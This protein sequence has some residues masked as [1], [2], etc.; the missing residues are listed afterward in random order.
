MFASLNAKQIPEQ[1]KQLLAL[2]RQALEHNIQTA[3]PKSLLSLLND[4]ANHLE[5]FWSP[6]GHLNSVIGSKEWRDCY[7]ECLPLLTE[8][9][10]FIYQNQN[11]Y[12][13]LKDCSEILTIGENKMLKDFLLGCQLSGIH[14]D[15]EKRQQVRSLFERL[16][17]LSQQFQNNIVDSMKKF[18]FHTLD[19]AELEGLPEHVILN[20][21]KKAQDEQ[22]SGYVLGLD[23]PTYIAVITYAKNQKLRK[24]F[25]KAYGTRASD[26]SDY[27]GNQFDNTDVI[28]E[29]LEK[30]QQLAGLVG[31]KNYAAYSLSNKMAQEIARV[32][33]FLNR[34]KDEVKPITTCDVQEIKVFAKSKG[35]EKD[36]EPWDMAY[37]IQMRQQELFSIDQEALRD[38]FP[39]THV[40]KGLNE[41]FLQLYGLNLEKVSIKDTWHSD[42]E[43]YQLKQNNKTIGYVYCDWFSREGK[44]GGAWM[45]TLQT[46]CR[47][48]D[49][50]IQHAIAT[51]TCNFAKPAPQQEAGLTH[52]ELLTLLHEF[53]HCMHHI[54]SEVDEFSVSGVHGVEWDAVELPSQWMENWGWVEQWLKI[55]SRH[56][57]TQETLPHEVFL[58]LLKVKNDLIGLY[59]SRQIL[60]ASYDIFIHSQKAPQSKDEVHQQYLSLLTEIAVWPVDYNQRFPQNFS[61]IFAGGYAAG[62]Y[63]YLWADV[64]SSDAFEWFAEDLQKISE[65]GSHFRK[66]IMSKGGSVSALDAFIAFRGREPDQNALLRAYGLGQSS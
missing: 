17:E 63:S 23:Q 8:H 28:Q 61:H 33:N 26:Q 52:E 5:K 66:E 46:R 13:K 9:E 51:L 31:L 58:Q 62:Y 37:F 50:S 39:L 54:L 24:L 19:K 16:D 22:V 29:T 10:T 3:N 7:Q 32:E 20:A 59:L 38:Y 4:Q 36:L 35:Y 41:L 55:F 43:C 34:L 49:G 44:R 6:V 11:L 30:R 56:I 12:Q 2:Q 18:R 15:D 45:D 57:K 53:G 1:L 27:D 42:V 47:L 48:S 64:L 25:F 14:L 65:K 40:M 21:Q 60:F